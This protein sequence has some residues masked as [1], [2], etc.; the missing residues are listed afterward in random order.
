MFGSFD[1]TL[2]PAYGRDYKSKKEALEALNAGK[3]FLAQGIGGSGYTTLVE[4]L[5]FAPGTKSVTVRY[6]KLTQVAVFKIRDGVA[7]A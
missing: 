2:V 5:K 3:D 4:L 6:K 1:S 7:V